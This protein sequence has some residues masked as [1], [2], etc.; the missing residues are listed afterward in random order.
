M[1][2]RAPSHL[3]PGLLRLIVSLIT[4]VSVIVAGFAWWDYT[5]DRATASREM[6]TAAR[7]AAANFERVLHERFQHLSS[8]ASSPAFQSADPA[9]IQ[10]QLQGFDPATRGFGGGMIWIDLEGTVMASSQPRDP[11]RGMSVLDAR[12]ASSVLK[13]RV[14]SV[15]SLV[16]PRGRP[17]VVLAVASTDAQGRLNGGVVGSMRLDDVRQLV[18]GLALL[19]EDVTIADVDDNLVLGGSLVRLERVSNPPRLWQMRTARV[20]HEMGVADLNGH[21]DQIVGFATVQ[22]SR[23]VVSV[24]RSRQAVLAPYKR[25]LVLNLGLLAAVTL[26]SLFVVIR[27]IRRLRAAQLED[28]RRRLSIARQRIAAERLGA[29]SERATVANTVAGAVRSELGVPWCAIVQ[30]GPTGSHREIGASG[31]VPSTL[32]TLTLDPADLSDPTTPEGIQLTPLAPTGALADEMGGARLMAVSLGARSDGRVALMGLPAGRSLVDGERAAAAA[33]VES[34]AQAFDRA[35]LIDHD[36]RRRRRDELLGV[37][38]GELLAIEGLAARA[39]RLVELLVPAVADFARVERVGRRSEVLA[40]RH[41]VPGRRPDVE[42]LAWSVQ[43]GTAPEVDHATFVTP[44][45]A[46]TGSSCIVG[47]IRAEG[48]DLVVL[49]GRDDRH[50]FTA[51]HLRF[52][53]GV[54]LR[55][56]VALT[57]GRRVEQERIVARE[58]QRSLLRTLPTRF[59]EGVR[60]ASRYLPGARDLDVGG[61]WFDAFELA[62]GRIALCVGDVV[63]HGLGATSAMGRLA[64][65]LRAVALAGPEPEDVIVHLDQFAL[66]TA[67]ARLATVA[68]IVLDPATGRVRYR[69]AGH[70]PPLFVGPDG[71]TRYLWEGRGAPLGVE[72][73]PVHPAG[74]LALVPGS[75]ILLFS[76]GLFERRG[77]LVDASLARLGDI[78]SGH[79]LSDPET[80]IDALVRASADRG[81]HTDDIAVVAARVDRV[82]RSEAL[83]VGATPS[84]LAP[85]RAAVRRWLAVSDLPADRQDDVVLAVSEILANAVEHGATSGVPV[86]LELGDEQGDVVA[87]VRDRGGWRESGDTAPRGR[88]LAIARTIADDLQ[89]ERGTDGTV[90]RLRFG[91]PASAPARLAEPTRSGG[92][93][94]AG[95]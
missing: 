77:E 95:H 37:L 84:A 44:A 49:L 60:L 17:R 85:A 40:C 67:G 71:A 20:G 13:S 5:I 66:Q 24:A 1:S 30:T 56:G 89:L 86:L 28:E 32:A 93:T 4:L 16:D 74:E 12:Y 22:A 38:E 21:P 47:P 61:D 80:M 94:G 91:A 14:P 2:H 36:M 34:A 72:G 55:A 46:L 73:T 90:V 83:A 54:G 26:A 50:P 3:T 70:P 31:V 33:L 59:G 65:A 57:R 81:A 63:G 25:S 43:E 18:P 51:D 42:N 76:D 88:G 52:V 7:A 87:V 92:P 69:L 15:Q 79:A 48:L 39:R 41:R 78:A 19:R 23:W 11:Q 9:A 58:L 64:S 29:A 45:G 27:S 6:R 82:G 68:Y 53:D 8:L 10:K 35:R 62:D 75:T